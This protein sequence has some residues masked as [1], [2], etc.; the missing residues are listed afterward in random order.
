MTEDSDLASELTVARTARFIATVSLT[1]AIFLGQAIGYYMHNPRRPI[2]RVCGAV[3]ICV[4]FV[5]QPIFLPKSRL[6]VR[7]FN[8]ST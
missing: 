8:K 2:R 6:V 3:L 4:S 7:P 1:I 5:Y